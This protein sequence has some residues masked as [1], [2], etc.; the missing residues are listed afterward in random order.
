MIF[1]YMKGR[2]TQLFNERQ[3]SKNPYDVNG[4]AILFKY[5]DKNIIFHK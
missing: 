1:I 4:N 3:Q 2:K 5:T